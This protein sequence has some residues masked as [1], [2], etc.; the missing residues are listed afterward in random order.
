M[1]Q[2]L[3]SGLKALRALGI[4]GISVDVY[5]GIVEGAAPMEYDWCV[6]VRRVPPCAHAWRRRERAQ[7]NK[8]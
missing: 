2:A 6:R 7:G 4:N 5:W 3:R 8:P 1:S